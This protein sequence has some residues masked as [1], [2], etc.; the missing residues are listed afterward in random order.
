MTPDTINTKE[1]KF[2]SSLTD[3]SGKKFTAGNDIDIGD[4]FTIR[5]ISPGFKTYFYQTRTSKTQIC[6]HFTVGVITGDVASLT[7]ENNHMSVPYVVDRQGNIYRLFDDAFWSYHLGASAIG[8][9]QVM[10]K[11]SIGIEI[12]NYGPLKERDGKFVDAYGNTYTTEYSNVDSVSYRGYDFYAKMTDRQKK[13]VAHLLQYLSA[14]HDIPLV[15]K[16]DIGNV[17]KSPEE[18]TQFTGIFCHSNVRQDK[19]DLPPEH[20]FQ[21][22][23]ALE[24][25]TEEPPAKNPEPA[26]VDPQPETDMSHREFAVAEDQNGDPIVVEVEHT[27]PAEEQ[28]TASVLDRIL[29][30]ISSL[31]HRS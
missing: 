18:A 26:V 22:K 28:V 6:L 29:Q 3:S 25:K 8:G 13:A 16:D 14:K 5:P 17:F 21:I 20:I 10:S 27:E 30:W 4:G 2:A 7:K 31:F 19:F 1:T 15:F 23:D 12:S 9:N 24:T 11:Q